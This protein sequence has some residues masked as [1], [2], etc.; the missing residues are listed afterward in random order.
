MQEVD[1]WH[2]D[3]VAALMAPDSWVAL[4]GL[5]WLEPGDNP[6]GS[7][8]GLPVVFPEKA[9]DTLGTFRLEGDSVSMIMATGLPAQVDGQ[10]VQRY[11]LTGMET[12]PVVHFEDLSW[13][14][15]QR[16]DKYGIRLWDGKHPKIA[17]TVHIERFPINTDWRISAR[18]IPDST[19][20]TIRMRNVLDMEMDMET[21]G[22]LHFEYQGQSYELT[23]LDGGE[24]EFFMVFADATSGAETYPGGRYLYVDRPDE[25]G[26]TYLDFNKAYNPPCAFTEFAT[27]LLPPAE[28]R[29]DLAITAGE[30]NY[31]DH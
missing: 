20:Q 7:A 2:Q 11:T 30:L 9:P 4:A 18:W 29:L 12:S 27:C 23:A 22:R 3:R 8:S 28:N 13:I 17:D 16:T 21:E 15:I 26:N 10:S 19:G 14:L 25:Q 5:F 6:F 1:A 24:N 31:G